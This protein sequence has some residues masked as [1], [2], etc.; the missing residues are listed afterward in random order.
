MR[1]DLDTVVLK[2]LRKDPKQRYA[3]AQAFADD[4]KRYLAFE[5]IAARPYSELQ[6]VGK[7]LRRNSVAAIAAVIV[8]LSI[9]TGTASTLWQASIASAQAR[10]ANAEAQQK[11]VEAQKARRATDEAIANARRADS[12]ALIAAEERDRADEG[13]RIAISERDRADRSAR[14]ARTATNF[15]VAARVEVS[16]QRDEAVGQKQRAQKEAKRSQ[17]VSAFLTSI[18]MTGSSLQPD[19]VAARKLSV[20]DILERGV[21]NSASSLRAEPEAL[22]QVLKTIGDVYEQLDLPVKA[23]ELAQSHWSSV[24]GRTSTPEERLLSLVDLGY[25]HATLGEMPKGRE[26]ASKVL[27][28]I[29]SL[30]REAAR[31]RGLGRCFAG[32]MAGSISD[33]EKSLDL[34]KRGVQELRSLIVEGVSKE[35]RLEFSRC[36][37]N[38]AKTLGANGDIDVA[39]AQFN[40]IGAVLAP[41]AAEVPTVIASVEGARGRVLRSAFRLGEAAIAYR[42]AVA[43]YSAAGALD[44]VV[45]QREALAG[46]DAQLGNR[47]AAV[48]GFAAV[49]AF[50]ARTATTESLDMDSAIFRHAEALLAMGDARAACTKIIELLVRVKSGGASHQRLLDGFWPSIVSACALGGRNDFAK[51]ILENRRDWYESRKRQPP[52]NAYGYSSALIAFVQSDFKAAASHLDQARASPANKGT[53]PMPTLIYI[54]L[55]RAQVALALN[56]IATADESLSAASEAFRRFAHYRERLPLY[57]SFLSLKGEYLA[58][59]GRKTESFATL[60]EAL[61]I[62]TRA[63]LLT[64]QNLLLTR[65]RL[66]R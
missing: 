11:D 31:A 30:P 12:A 52:A 21:A 16:E 18:F 41:I 15:A 20:V 9:L 65:N 44:N 39:F 32:D 10:R 26:I 63:E 27:V 60:S 55:L 24:S 35:D 5:P 4:L 33:W 19:P 47:E 64:S 3:T 45:D 61:A 34:L 37:K 42:S 7:F 23:L 50:R 43:I 36:S 56:D 46:L 13:Q 8:M 58:S 59:V 38:Y 51:E 14:L 66:A 49:L 29:E 6:K 22:E 1:G 53:E 40:E 48:E 2:A 54:W 28:E 57:A 25:M 62:Q 17:A